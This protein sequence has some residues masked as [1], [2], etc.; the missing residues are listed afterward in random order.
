MLNHKLKLEVEISAPIEC[1]MLLNW[2]VM[3]ELVSFIEIQL[4]S[5]QIDKGHISKY[6]LGEK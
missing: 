6:A 5:L 4:S 1:W 2:N 3:N